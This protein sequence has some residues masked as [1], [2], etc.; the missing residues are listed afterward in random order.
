M[1]YELITLYNDDAG[2]VQYA[3]SAAGLPIGVWKDMGVTVVHPASVTTTY[4]LQ[5][6]NMT[7]VE[8]DAGIENDWCDYIVIGTKSAAENIPIDGDDVPFGRVRLKMDTASGTNA[9]QARGCV[10]Q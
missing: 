8:V 10:K 9:I 1:N 7:Q 6:S 5:V 4:T 2:G 3:P